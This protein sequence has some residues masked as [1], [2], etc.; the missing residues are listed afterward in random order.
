MKNPTSNGI[1]EKV[2][3]LMKDLGIKK[4][5]LGEILAEEGVEEV[6]Q[7][8]YLRADR[9]LRSTSEVGVDKLVKIAHFFGKPVSFFLDSAYGLAASEKTQRLASLPLQEIEKNLR[10]MGLGEDYIKNEIEQLRAMELYKSV[11]R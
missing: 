7:Q 5:R 8:K 6:N 10:N 3:H 11:N 4:T 1:R 2:A 9:F